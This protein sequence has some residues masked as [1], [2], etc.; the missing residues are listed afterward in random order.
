MKKKRLMGAF[1]LLIV[2]S[3]VISG[4]DA[5]PADASGRASEIQT[6]SRVITNNNGLFRYSYVDDNG[7]SYNLDT[8]ADNMTSSLKKGTTLPE[9]YDGREHGIITGIKDQGVSGCCWAFAAMKSAEAN[10]LKKRII[11]ESEADFSENHLAWYTYHATTDKTN[12]VYGDSYSLSS[13]SSSHR[14]FNP[15]WGFFDNFLFGEEEE[16]DTAVYEL[17][18]MAQFA[19]SMLAQW[20]GIE[21]ETKA[22]FNAQSSS[23]LKNMALAM[24]ANGETLRYDSL[25]HLQ[26]AECYDNASIDEIKQAVLDYG[27]VDIAMYYDQSGFEGDAKTG[28][29]F[30]QTTYRGEAAKNNANHCVTIVGWD[31]NYSKN[32]FKRQPSSDGAW[33]IANS[34][35]S[36]YN[37]DGY[38]WLSYEE[39]SICDIYTFD[40]ESADNYNNIYQY[41]GYGWNDGVFVSKKSISGANVF[42]NNSSDYQM[43]K[44]VSF[45]TITDNQ[46]YNIKV[47]KNVTSVPTDGTYIKE[48]TV[49]GTQKYQGYHT[50]NLEEAC[51]IKPGENFAVVI[52]YVYDAS[53]GNEAY[54]PVEGPNN[55]DSMINKKFSSSENES[56]YYL[57]N[58]WS[59]MSKKG[60]NNIA[61]KAFTD[62][63]SQDTYEVYASAEKTN[64]SGTTETVTSEENKTEEAAKDI[65]I[66]LNKQAVILGK[67][68]KYK[69]NVNISDKSVTQTIKY[70]SSD[71]QVAVINSDNVIT[72]V[73]NGKAVIT[74][75]L[76]NGNKA[77]VTV[78]VKNA[79]SKVTANVSSKN[80]KKGK[81]FKIK[82]T[83]PEGSASNDISFISSDKKMAK[84]SS[85]GKVTAL[86]KGKATITVKTFN[87]KKAKVKIKVI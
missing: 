76:Q 3:I 47:Y 66:S 49:S 17:G 14:P 72:A 59:D 55:K 80:I 71:E 58:K 68:E 41:D 27:A 29:S 78:I 32:N 85:N 64:V 7:E 53:T 5:L 87:G 52:E 54:L 21:A 67:G 6:I 23:E 1:G 84:V 19:V 4:T 28:T 61:I 83:L 77:S 40:M 24:S 44:A 37:S 30:Y 9:S 79:P 13:S 73:N 57:N 10:M 75:E 60:K 48:C 15:H 34:Y 62:N 26:N 18:G 56:F 69:L 36:E 42:T 65:K 12:P 35:G 43:L 45:Y 39:E 50:V 31:D 22:P 82:I 46:K 86:R 2:S 8:S 25:G 81:S 70:S 38:F 11:S 63:I 20:S 16:S 51:A 33:L 74:L